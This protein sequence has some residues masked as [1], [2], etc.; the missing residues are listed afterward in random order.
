MDTNDR[1]RARSET[2]SA[3]TYRR[4]GVVLARGKGAW[5]QDVEG[6]WYLDLLA[7]I[8]V[9]CLGHA[10][11]ALI[12]AV[13]RQM[14][15]L[16]HVSNYFVTPT[17]TELAEELVRLS[18]AEQVFLCNSGTEANEAALK[19]A[20]SWGL[21]HG[22]RTEVVA[23]LGSFHGRTLG[24][25]SLTGQTRHASGFGPLP[26]GVRFVPFGDLEALREAVSP[27]TCAV[28]LEPIQGEGGVVVPPAGYL[29][30]VWRLCRE[31]DVLLVTD[32]IQ[33]GIGRTGTLFAYEQLGYEPDILTL[34]K[35]L[36]GGFPIGAVLAK[37]EVLSVWSPGVHGSTFGGNPLAAAAARAVL[38]EVSNPRLLARVRRDGERF[39]RFF[40]NLQ[41]G[42]AAK[43]IVDVRGRG[44]LIGI[45]LGFDGT[46]I[47]ERALE[48]GLLLNCTA[49]NVL[50]LA[51]PLTIR[52]SEVREACR[53]LAR[54]LGF[55][56]LS[57]PPDSPRTGRFLSARRR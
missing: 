19:L 31:R 18:F 15:T 22:G 10:P 40:R 9:N 37:R 8:A 23:M 7:G 24:S 39:L 30:E 26:G 33:V 54:V 38:R 29:E 50:R 45:E 35:G 52:T 11:A 34:A 4:L 2:V 36:A 43:R 13:S 3:P 5:V 6:K 44:L 46:P 27:A 53:R 21:A 12:R 20:R 47:V 25:L 1:W 48:A 17:A 49:G 42:D 14:R 55:Q 57:D 41:A 51:P 56:E 28:F 16:H 32:E